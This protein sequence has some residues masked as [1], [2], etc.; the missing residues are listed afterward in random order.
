M[1]AAGGFAPSSVCMAARSTF[2]SD[3]PL[4]AG[5][6]SLTPPAK[7]T[8]TSTTKAL[9]T[10]VAP[11]V[12]MAAATD[13]ELQRGEELLR[14]AAAK[15]ILSDRVIDSTDDIQTGQIY[16]GDGHLAQPVLATQEEGF[17]NKRT[18]ARPE[19][20]HVRDDSLYETSMSS[21]SQQY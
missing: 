8:P 9:K 17:I 13:L 16:P 6:P 1:G 3:A 21:S 18:T 19:P 2:S 7:V 5:S 12:A 10:M 20:L 11:L 15:R 14:T 4:K